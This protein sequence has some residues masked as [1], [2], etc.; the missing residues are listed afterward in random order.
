MTATSRFNTWALWLIAVGSVMVATP[1]LL[2]AGRASQSGYILVGCVFGT[3]FGQIMCAAFW[4]AL[5]SWPLHRRVL[6]SLIWSAM[7]LA[8][9]A[10]SFRFEHLGQI[11]PMVGAA[12]GTQWILAQIPLWLL[13]YSLGLR[14]QPGEQSDAGNA[15]FGLRQL[16]AFTFGIAVVLGLMRWIVT[17]K[18]LTFLNEDVA[19]WLFLALAAMLMSLPLALA[20]LLPRLAWL[21]VLLILLM[22]ALATAW[23][24]SLSR[25]VAPHGGPDAM[26]LV[27]MNAFTSFWVLVFAAVARM[28][29][30][31]LTVSRRPDTPSSPL[32]GT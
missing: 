20:A 15:Q 11:L 14:F 13:A 27:W 28:N 16:M 23:E 17:S 19:T 30:Y 29:G 26:H 4:T 7:L 12:L 6:F 5:G 1:S 18:V 22:T 2:S 8:A 32:Q 10:I 9:I 25:A 24:H 31:R 21:A 3:P